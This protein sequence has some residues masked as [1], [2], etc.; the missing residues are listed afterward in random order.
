MNAI[1]PKIYFISGLGADE[2]AFHFLDLSFCIP[3]FMKWLPHQKNQNLH[4]YAMRL[5]QSIPEE[6]PNIV[7]LSFG[8]MLASEIA[9]AKP[10]ARVV[11][12]SSNKTMLEFPSYFRVGKYIPLYRLV[13]NKLMQLPKEMFMWM[14]SAEGKEQKEMLQQMAV[15]TNMSFAKWAVGSILKWENTTIPKNVMH[16]HGSG[17]VLLPIKYVKADHVI[18]GGKHSMVLDKADEISGLLKEHFSKAKN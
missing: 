2:R 18:N 7:G 5:M 17:D 9:L 15:D 1:K 8:G 10:K 12:I 13:P 3:F 4:A 11:L 16:I 6:N 14:M